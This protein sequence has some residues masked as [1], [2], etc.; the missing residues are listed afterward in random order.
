MGASGFLNKSI[1]RFTSAFIPAVGFFLAWT[2]FAY[3]GK[4]I[5]A[6]LDRHL[7]YAV[8]GAFTYFCIH[9]LLSERLTK[10]LKKR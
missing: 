10:K 7:Y 2:A 6:L 5:D 1:N 9:Y 8:A 4:G 3:F